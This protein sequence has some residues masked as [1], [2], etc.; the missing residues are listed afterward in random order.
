MHMPA[1]LDSASGRMYYRIR[2]RKLSR[3]F[4]D[5]LE[6]LRA[7]WPGEKLYVVFD[8]FSPHRHPAVRAWAADNDVELVFLPTYR[9]WLNWIESSVRGIAVFRIGQR[10]SSQSHRTERCDRRLHALAKHPR[11]TE[12]RLRSRL[13]D[14][15]LDRVPAL[16]R[17]GCL[18]SH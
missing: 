6:V 16:P 17:Q 9:S 11:R 3:E 18:T 7:R 1:A 13:P 12:D 14:P 4:L 10:R 8:N 15:N 2:P 5:F